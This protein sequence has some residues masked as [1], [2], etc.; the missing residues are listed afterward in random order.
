MRARKSLQL[1]R[2]RDLQGNSLK[3]IQDHLEKV[4]TELDTQYRL[5]FQDIQTLQVTLTIT[6]ILAV[7]TPKALGD[8]AGLVI[9][10]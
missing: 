1:P 6:Y 2:A 3:Q 8:K 10:L 4:Q 5:M 7:K 9:I